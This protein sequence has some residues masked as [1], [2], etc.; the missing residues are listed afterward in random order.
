MKIS[1]TKRA[2]RNY[3]SIRNKITEEWG[4]KVAEAFEQKIIDFLDILEEFP[5]IGIIEVAD[6]HI[7]SFQVTRQTRVF[8]RIKQEQIIILALFDVRQN[9]T[10]KPR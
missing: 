9:P 10:K 4:E 1:F 3:A 8:Y 5:R 7:F 2:E 6:K